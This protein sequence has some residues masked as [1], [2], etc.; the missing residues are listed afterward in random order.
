MGD[1]D[2]VAGEAMGDCI[3]G[4]E[5]PIE[6]D[7]RGNTYIFSRIFRSKQLLVGSLVS[8]AAA[9]K[10]LDERIFPKSGVVTLS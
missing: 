8:N 1:Q 4:R 2:L 10:A 3:T 6:P 7:V 5:R 9:L